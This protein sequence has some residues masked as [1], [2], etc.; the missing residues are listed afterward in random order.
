MARSNAAVA[1]SCSPNAAWV[2][3]TAAASIAAVGVLGMS[4]VDPQRPPGHVD[5]Q[6]QAGHQHRRPCAPVQHQ[7][8]ADEKQGHPEGGEH[9]LVLGRAV[10]VAHAGLGQRLAPQP[11][12]LGSQGQPAPQLIPPAG[13]EPGSGV[14]GG[15][16]PIDLA[17]VGR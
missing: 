15:Q 1:L 17:H 11:V 5:G 7:R 12:P 2:A 4:C 16:V 9:G 14:A 10:V 6:N 8:E 13:V 3:P